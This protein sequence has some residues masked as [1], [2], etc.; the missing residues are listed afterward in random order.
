MIINITTMNI[1][2]F[3]LLDCL[4]LAMLKGIIKVL[5]VHETKQTFLHHNKWQ[6]L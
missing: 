1:A 4:K 6:A 3:C 5:L 2:S